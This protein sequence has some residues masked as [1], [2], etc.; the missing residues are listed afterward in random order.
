MTLPAVDGPSPATSCGVARL[1]MRWMLAA[2]YVAA[3]IAHLRAPEQ[4]LAITPSWVPL[5]PQV[6]FLTGVFELLASAALLTRPWRRC[7]GIIM[8]AYALCVWPANFKHAF[9][10][11]D[12]QYVSSSWLYHG[13]RLALQPVIMW[14]AL[15]CA[16]VTDW[17]WRSRTV[18]SGVVTKDQA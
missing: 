8:A 10:G 17:P 6:I 14:W 11:I 16:E 12:L 2:L 7:A 4:L 15:Y 13:P 3:G 9:E 1:A 5:A 18:S